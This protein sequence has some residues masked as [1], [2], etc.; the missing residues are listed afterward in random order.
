[1]HWFLRGRQAT[2]DGTPPVNHTHSHSTQ[3]T[4]SRM[5]NTDAVNTVQQ[6]GGDLALMPVLQTVLQT[7]IKQP[8]NLPRS[9]QGTSFRENPLCGLGCLHLSGQIKIL[10]MH[11]FSS[12]SVLLW[13]HPEDDLV[14]SATSRRFLQWSILINTAPVLM[15]WLSHCC[16]WTHNFTQSVCLRVCIYIVSYTL[17][18][19]ISGSN[20]TVFTHNFIII[21]SCSCINNISC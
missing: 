5:N 3:T 13:T 7:L 18:V 19:Y 10:E 17:F 16:A 20:N 8:Q 15:L 6:S 11:I 2:W 21:F 1:M 14:I 9:Y 12:F 4:D